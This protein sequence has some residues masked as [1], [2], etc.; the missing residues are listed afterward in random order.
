MLR[1][2][3][4]R[5]GHVTITSP[6]LLS[7]NTQCFIFTHWTW[8]CTFIFITVLCRLD[9]S[10]SLSVASLMI[11]GD[12]LSIAFLSLHPA[13]H[14]DDRETRSDFL[15]CQRNLKA[16]Q[17]EKPGLWATTEK[18][19]RKKCLWEKYSCWLSKCSCQAK[20][21]DNEGPL[22]SST[23]ESRAL[24]SCL[25]WTSA[26]VIFTLKSGTCHEQLVF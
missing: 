22:Y 2:T 18:H 19:W 26:G 17:N 12:L 9:H 6:P 11:S 14:C 25:L 24:L 13:I 15:S 7:H 4:Y 10:V 20:A 21:S 23:A 3:C 1:R 5:H 8:S 16:G